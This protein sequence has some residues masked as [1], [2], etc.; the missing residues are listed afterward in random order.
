MWQPALLPVSSCS[1]SS[2]LADTPATPLLGA[3][4]DQ[5]EGMA[6]SRDDIDSRP[7]GRPIEEPH[8]RARYHVDAAVAARLICAIGVRVR[9]LRARAIGVSPRRIVQ[10]VAYFAEE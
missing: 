8:R 3:W 4:I 10:K 6:P 9:V 5:G 2:V 1:P 7:I